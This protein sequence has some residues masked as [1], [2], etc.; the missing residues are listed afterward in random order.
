MSPTL[1]APRPEGEMTLANRKGIRSLLVILNPLERQQFLPGP[2]EDRLSEL[3]AQVHFVDGETIAPEEWECLLRRLDPEVMLTCWSTPL[4]PDGLPESLRYVCHLAGSVKNLTTGAQIEK[5]LLVSNWGNSISRT[6]AEWALFHILACLRQAGYWLVAMHQ[7]AAWKSR[8]VETS[9]LFSRTVGIHGFGAVS[10]ELIQL[11]KPFGVTISV[12]APDIDEASA[13]RLHV[14]ICPDLDTLFFSNDIIV[15]LAPLLPET[16]GI[17]Q[18]RHLRMIRPGGVFVNIGRGAVVDPE[19]L[20]KVAS[21]G[22]IQFGLDVFTEEPLPADS[23]LR[24]L[25]NVVLTPHLGGPTADRRC[26]AGAFAIHNL[27][28]YAEGLPLE[29][30][31]TKEVFDRSS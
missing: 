27:R 12:C 3:A 7:E 4:L 1:E 25:H 29:A 2:F 17:V 28:A 30:V 6:V 11:L 31:V 15:E 24:G 20:L 10:K 23:K 14:R 5:G 8:A 13:H 21:E 26:D 16:V 19:A 22:K 18:E 9:S